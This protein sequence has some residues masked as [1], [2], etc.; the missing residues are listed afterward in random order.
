MT[1]PAT[2]GD[3][4]LRVDAFEV[5]D[6]QHA[7]VHP[8]TI[9]RGGPATDGSSLTKRRQF[10]QAGTGKDPGFSAGGRGFSNGV[11]TLARLEVG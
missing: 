6:Q 5:P 2:P 10:P 1:V 4:P 3:A 7:E 9:R 8:G 11:L